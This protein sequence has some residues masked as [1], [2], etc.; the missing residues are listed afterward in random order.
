V[1]QLQ[2]ILS[3][4]KPFWESHSQESDSSF[5]FDQRSLFV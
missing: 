3:M 2:I 5:R 4:K 1:Q